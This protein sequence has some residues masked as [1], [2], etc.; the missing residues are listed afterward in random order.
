MIKG[1]LV[2]ESS[3]RK[4]CAILS[5]DVKGYSLLMGQ[6]EVATVQSLKSYREVIAAIVLQYRGRVVDSP[7]DNIL[8]EFASV[9]D[10]VE[11]AAAI[12]REI[13]VRNA[14]LP[15][16]RRMKFRI[17]VN[18]GDVIKEGGRLYGDGVNITARIESLAEAGEICISETV[19][20]HVEKKLPLAYEYLGEHEVK[21]IE[22]P[23]RVYRII[24]ER[25]PL[26]K[27][28]DKTK[29]KLQ[30][31][32]DE[33]GRKRG[34]VDT[35]KVQTQGK[36]RV[37]REA[38]DY[39]DLAGRIVE[40]I[41]E[42]MVVLDKDLRVVLAIPSFYQTF[43][44]TPGKTEG[45]LI[46]ELGNGQWNIPRLR[47]LLEDIIPKNASFD[48][49]EME[50]D[51]PVIGRKT[52][53]LIARR[54]V[55]RGA[56]SNLILLVI[57]DI[58]V[59][60]RAKET[61]TRARAEVEEQVKERTAELV[62]KTRELSRSNAELEY[63]A[64][65]ASHD[66][67]EPLIVVSGFLNLLSRRY[68]RKLDDKAKTFISQALDASV[69]MQ[70][71]IDDLLSFS[72]VSTG[73]KEFEPTDWNLVLDQVM[74]DLQP[75]IEESRARIFR[76]SLPSVM[77]DPVQ[78]ARVFQNLIGNALKF[79]TDSPPKVHIGAE[80]LDHE[81]QIFVKDNGIGIAPENLEKIFS[82]LE[83][84]H[85]SEKYPG[86]GMGLAICKKIVERHGGR[87]WVESEPGK[88][89][90]FFF[91]MQTADK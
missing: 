24:A 30:L 73:G 31:E 54:I 16:D 8:A 27:I 86:T 53:R 38:L 74:K 43:K 20:D 15:E 78:L 9:V 21:N 66:L 81:L 67:K 25:K 39:I 63:F 44:A 47:E 88:G 83:R 10:A 37:L 34:E 50:H 77:A 71:L 3:T 59:Q 28:E 23:I 40:T 57:E 4:L 5:A 6:D 11:C 58:T 26:G 85:P 76:D 55:Q 1:K 80:G 51:F 82:M 33:L 35:Q 48:D 65:V 90:T 13:K 52:M 36:E 49:F 56:T 12:Q 61:L 60:K 70:K 2:E 84:L 42:P 29:E 72:R 17:G 75:A 46:Y 32:L 41:G 14:E 19:Y 45:R 18:L 87:I 62:Q 64:H 79:R 68:A 91:T 89:S 69:R 7:G 22:K